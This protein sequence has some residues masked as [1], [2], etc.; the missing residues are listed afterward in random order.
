MIVI[1]AAVTGMGLICTLI[2]RT[3][4]GVLIGIQLMMLGATMIFVSAKGGSEGHLFGLFIALSTL[5]Q[6]VS[7]LAIAARLFMLKKRAEM[8]EITLLKH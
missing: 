8:D 4:L 5:V 7:G 2:R 3:L 6:L 1:A